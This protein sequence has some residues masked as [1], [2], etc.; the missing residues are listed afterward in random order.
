MSKMFLFYLLFKIIYL[1]QYRLY[2]IASRKKIF[3]GAMGVLWSF[4][5]ELKHLLAPP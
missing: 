2:K 5:G 4:L 1:L 3:G